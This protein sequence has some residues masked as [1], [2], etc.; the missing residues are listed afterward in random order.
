MTI[1]SR[2]LVPFAIALAIA[3]TL[4]VWMTAGAVAPRGGHSWTLQP[5]HFTTVPLSKHSS[6]NG[7]TDKNPAGASF[8]AT[9][10][11]VAA[12][13]DIGRG[14]ELCTLLD[15]VSALCNIEF[16]FAGRGRLELQGVSKGNIST[17]AITGGTGAFTTAR[18]WAVGH[19]HHVTVTFR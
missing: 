15:N 8:Q 5:M 1:V 12:G 6:S 11:L 7:A 3:A 19:K 4:A 16:R 9:A 13:E 17:F 18:G 14:F 10:N 2:R